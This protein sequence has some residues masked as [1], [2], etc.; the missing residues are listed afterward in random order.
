[1]L[2]VATSA[3]AQT[4][5][6][7]AENGVNRGI[8]IKTPSTRLTAAVMASLMVS[9]PTDCTL[10]CLGNQECYS[11]NLAASPDGRH[12]C[13]LLNTDKF[14]NADKLVFSQDFEHY[15]IK[16]PCMNN[17]CQH[18]AAF[19]R[20]IYHRDD[21]E[22]VC[23]PGFTGKHCGVEI[24]ECS[25]NPC[26]NGG[27]CTDQVNGYVCTCQAGFIGADCENENWVKMPPSSV[28]FSARDDIYG[29]FTIPR[30][31]N[32][33]TFKLKYLNG[34]VNCGGSAEYLSRWGCNWPGF[35]HTLGVYIT[36]TDKN[37][38][39]PANNN[40]KLG[41]NDCLRE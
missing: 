36:D 24:D 22:C 34:H 28:C 17:P 40:Y 25:S 18:G 3:F 20:P 12:T 19:C 11:Y 30:P 29:A 21:Y 16:T 15:N 32:I 8:F 37:R 1:M 38:L 26:L 2:G 23:K 31:G 14:R 9:C 39:L 6:R 33:I 7:D 10:E 4:F 13:E 35:T 41:G 27:S 5:R